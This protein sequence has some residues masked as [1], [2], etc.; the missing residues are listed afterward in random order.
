MALL[1]IIIGQGPIPVLYLLRNNQKENLILRKICPSYDPD[2]AH[3]IYY[4]YCGYKYEMLI[5]SLTVNIL[6][7]SKLF[8][9]NQNP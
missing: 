1:G 5:L 6:G 2:I 7:L 3:M 4:T 8:K 9:V